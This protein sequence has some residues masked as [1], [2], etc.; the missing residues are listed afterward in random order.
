MVDAEQH[1]SGI[2]AAAVLRAA[3]VAFS[4]PDADEAEQSMVLVSATRAVAPL[5]LA[6]LLIEEEVV[7]SIEEAMLASGRAAASDEVA[8]TLDNAILDS[9]SPSGGPGFDHVPTEP[10][11]ISSMVERFVFPTF[12][13]TSAPRGYLI[14]HL[15]APG[16]VGALIGPP[17]AGKSVLAPHIAYAVAQGRPVFGLRTKPGRVL[18]AA[19]EDGAGM[20]QR[21]RA[22]YDRHGNTPN[23]ALVD[24]TNLRDQEASAEL[25]AAVV[26]WNASLLVI[27]TLS[28]AWSGLDENSSVGLGEVVTFARR[29]A[30]TGCAV[31]LIHHTAKAGD[32]SPRGHS[33]LNGT[34]D[35]C[36]ALGERGVDGAIR[37]K[38]QKNRNGTPDR[39]IAFRIAIAEL[40]EDED[41]D[42]ITAPIA[43]EVMAER[44]S[45]PK[46]SPQ[47]SIAWGEFLKLQA[48][49]SPDS[50]GTS[51][52]Q[53]DEWKEACVDAALSS[54]SNPD[55]QRRTFTRAVGDLYQLGFVVKS[56]A[57]G[58]QAVKTKE[59]RTGG[60]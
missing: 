59:R 17:S 41:G 32:G 30:A 49:T 8:S 50:A 21:V 46:L 51:V 26:E 57:S 14:K 4:A 25:H 12:C 47:Q 5:I 56:G 53:T 38:L 58:W 18:Y 28:A 23:L 13:A 54:S 1:I 15:L 20:R 40:G 37:A 9:M 44:S 24:I 36:L 2:A 60:Q 43:A 7:E 33:V 16:D 19:A 27:D 22:L 55:S 42:T 6:G 11:P 34:L 48:R 3:C 45:A 35:M 39:D 31:L 10:A 52:V 29:V